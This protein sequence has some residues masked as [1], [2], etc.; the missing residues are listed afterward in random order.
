MT[1]R[2][3]YVTTP[4]HGTFPMILL[5]QAMDH[6]TALAFARSIWPQCTVE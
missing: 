6:E 4:G 2:N 1:K 5:S 3:W